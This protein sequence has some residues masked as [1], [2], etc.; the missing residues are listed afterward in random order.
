MVFELGVHTFPKTGSSRRGN[1]NTTLLLLLHPIHGCG[2][3]VHFT[4][5][6]GTTRIEQHT[7]GSCGFTRVHMRTDA[8]IAVPADRSF[9]CHDLIPNK[10][11]SGEN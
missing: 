5:F 1:R 9:A 10:M 7:F 6:V 4:N 8:N 2:T 3:I 11:F